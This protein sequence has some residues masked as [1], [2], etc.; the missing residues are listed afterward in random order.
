[1]SSSSPRLA[2]RLASWTLVAAGSLALAG[3]L[4]PLHGQRVYNPDSKFATVSTTSEVLRSIQV[5]PIG[6]R[7]GQR[8]R[9]NLIFAFN[10]GGAPIEPPRYRLVI[11]LKNPTSVQS[12]VD[13]FTDRAE[14]ETVALDAAFRL[15]PAGTAEPVMSGNAFGRASYT[16]TRQRF[17]NVRAERDAQDR[18]AGIVSEQI[19]ARISAFIA[20]QGL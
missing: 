6:G 13:P 16:N 4:Q 3:C 9:N 2:R 15:I 1:M 18:A 14:I 20:T 8:V 17:S 19:R 12:V 7:V 10:G 5:V 11:D